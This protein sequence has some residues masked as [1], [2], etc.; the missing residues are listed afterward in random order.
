M[1]QSCEMLWAY[2]A[3]LC[4]CDAADPGPALRTVAEWELVR[5]RLRP[6]AGA[7]ALAVVVLDEE[8]RQQA[9]YLIDAVFELVEGGCDDLLFSCA[10]T[11][12]AVWAGTFAPHDA[13]VL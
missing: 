11:D 9:L 13:A 8:L 10:P 5:E 7:E 1:E 2:L 4:E 12:D 6:A 3:K